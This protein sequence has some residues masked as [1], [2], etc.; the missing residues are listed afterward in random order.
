MVFECVDGQWQQHNA[1]PEPIQL[2]QR[3]DLS[4]VDDDG[5]MAAMD[6]QAAAQPPGPHGS[7]PTRLIAAVVF[8]LRSRKCSGEVVHCRGTVES[9]AME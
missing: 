9:M 8:P 4:D 2:L 6:R 1:A 7:Q 5:Q 3:R